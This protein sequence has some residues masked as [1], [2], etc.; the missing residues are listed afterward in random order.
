VHAAA[1]FAWLHTQAFVIEHFGGSTWIIGL[2][3]TTEAYN[4]KC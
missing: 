1:V 2:D 3:D 4:G